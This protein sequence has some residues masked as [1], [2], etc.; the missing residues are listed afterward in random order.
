M[1]SINSGILFQQEGAEWEVWEKWRQW[2]CVTLI[3]QIPHDLSQGLVSSLDRNS[4]KRPSA[5]ASPTDTLW[6][7]CRSTG[8]SDKQPVL[9]QHAGQGALSTENVLPDS[10]FSV[11]TPYVQLEKKPVGEPSLST[12]AECLS[13]PAHCST[14]VQKRQGGCC[15]RGHSSPRL[16]KGDSLPQFVGK[17]S[18]N[19]R[20]SRV[21]D[22][23]L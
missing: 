3:R 16:K 12:E 15:A 8:L 5:L 14:Y 19:T 9:V 17:L 23:I 22:G 6:E 13:L 1:C 11:R 21:T 20:S 7:R 4:E 2:W 10:G 18:I